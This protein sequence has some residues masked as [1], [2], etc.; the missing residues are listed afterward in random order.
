MMAAPGL[1]GNRL[2]FSYIIGWGHPFGS[3]KG[4]V[5]ET[6]HAVFA[7]AAYGQIVWQSG[8]DGVLVAE[9]VLLF[10]PL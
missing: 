2:D 6:R 7:Q 8:G 5:K 1:V 4:I 10:W 9:K 3:W